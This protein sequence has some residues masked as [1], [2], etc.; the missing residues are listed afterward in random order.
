MP[1]LEKLGEML[2]KEDRVIV[3]NYLMWRVVM[4]LMPYLPLRYLLHMYTL[5]QSTTAQCLLYSIEER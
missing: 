1:Y 2:Q 5:Q 4:E 3:Y